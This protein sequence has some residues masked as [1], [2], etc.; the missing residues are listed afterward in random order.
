M[1][2]HIELK[3]MRWRL[4]RSNLESRCDIDLFYVDDRSVVMVSQREG[5]PA[6]GINISSG[7]EMIAAV[8]V[9]NYRLPL[10]TLSW[11]EHYP[12]RRHGKLGEYMT[13]ATY[14]MVCFRLEN[15]GLRVMSRQRLDPEG[16]R[17]CLEALHTTA[18]AL[19]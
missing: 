12:E 6:S 19:K 7:A 1:I 2:F 17:A 9:H 14:D 4:P 15:G 5:D 10:D 16:M 13:P 8:I 11:V 3:P 18:M